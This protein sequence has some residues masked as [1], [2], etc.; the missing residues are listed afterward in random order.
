[1]KSTEEKIENRIKD[2]PFFRFLGE[3]NVEELKKGIVNV[4][5]DRVK[6]D[7]DASYEYLL[8]PDDITATITDDVIER[9]QD[10][11]QEKLEKVLMER[12]MK[13]LGLCD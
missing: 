4:I 7:L 2:N 10:K 1:V 12:A 9:V 3:D 13:K 6:D 8:D 5:I 11:V